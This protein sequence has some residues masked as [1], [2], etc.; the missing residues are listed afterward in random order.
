MANSQIKSGLV[1]TTLILAATSFT[2]FQG[3]ASDGSTRGNRMRVQGQGETPCCG[4]CALGTVNATPVADL[5]FE[6]REELIKMRQ[7]EKLARDVYA[8]L[9]E[10]WGVD[11]FQITNSEQRH[12][13]AMERMLDRF[14]I[15]DPITDDARGVYADQEFVDLYNDLIEAGSVSLL[16]ALKV[17]A[18]IEELD[19]YDLRVAKAAVSDPVLINVYSNLERATRNHLRAFAAQVKAQNGTY[20]AEHLSQEEFDSIADSDFERGNRRSS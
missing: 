17:G 8:A 7:E 16:D 12:M 15:E 6:A 10:K 18:K 5:S 14:G 4:G 19:L 1:A 9:G 11:V 13:D 20:R 2:A 3:C